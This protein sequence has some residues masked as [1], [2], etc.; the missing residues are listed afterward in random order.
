M[1]EVALSDETVEEVRSLLSYLAEADKAEG[2]AALAQAI[3]P[4]QDR[5]DWSRLKGAS[6]AEAL[7][8]MNSL[9]ED[10]AKE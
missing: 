7:A 6:Y 10:E 3:A 1:D 8:Y 9:M 4:E 5:V 2:K